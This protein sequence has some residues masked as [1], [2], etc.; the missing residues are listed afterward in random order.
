MKTLPSYFTMDYFER[1]LNMRC[2][3]RVNS[4]DKSRFEI[5]P[6]SSVWVMTYSYWWRVTATGLEAKELC[7]GYFG[8]ATSVDSGGYPTWKIGNRNV[9]EDEA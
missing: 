1:V 3:A 6:R 7:V 8:E 2:T 5:A 9:V 4:G